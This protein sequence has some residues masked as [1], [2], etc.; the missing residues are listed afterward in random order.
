MIGQVQHQ[1]RVQA[2]RSRTFVEGDFGRT[3]STVLNQENPALGRHWHSQAAT[4]R[5]CAMIPSPRPTQ[6]LASMS[7]S[8]T[9]ERLDARNATFN[10]VAGSQYNTITFIMAQSAQRRPALPSNRIARQVMGLVP[11]ITFVLWS[12]LSPPL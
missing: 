10:N 11:W 5:P 12:I 2:G 9:A 7:T 6:H 4:C 8:F 3:S 1:R